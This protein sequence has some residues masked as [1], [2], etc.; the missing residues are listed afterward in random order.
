MARGFI[1]LGSDEP[2]REAQAVYA[3]VDALLNGTGKVSE[4]AARLLNPPEALRLPLHV[5]EHGDLVSRIICE[6]IPYDPD[7]AASMLRLQE[8]RGETEATD[9]EAERQRRAR[10]RRLWDFAMAPDGKVSQWGRSSEIDSALIL[11]FSRILSEATGRAF[12]FSRPAAGGK[13]TGPMWRALTA[14]MR[15]NQAAKSPNG[16]PLAGT[17]E[18]ALTKIIQSARSRQFAEICA[19]WTL[20][21]KARD[22]VEAPFAFRLALSMA[23]SSRRS[24]AIGE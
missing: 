2:S 3:A 8:H 18:E 22:V 15:A 13:P 4:I 1:F 5:P 9:P 16:G 19:D 10:A 17:Y 7:L 24:R 12:R 21:P 14:A 11:Y 6:L 20:G 23:R